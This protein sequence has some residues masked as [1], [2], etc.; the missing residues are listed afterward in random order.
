MRKFDNPGG[1]FNGIITVEAP[2]QLEAQP[3]ICE[4]KADTPT[5]G[6]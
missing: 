5:T 4:D 6:C 3:L 1:T 2:Q